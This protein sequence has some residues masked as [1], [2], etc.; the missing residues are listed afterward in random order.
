MV[1]ASPA[2]LFLSCRA[3]QAEAKGHFVLTVGSLSWFL[4]LDIGQQRARS[5]Q[6][7]WQKPP[8]FILQRHYQ[9]GQMLHS[10]T[11]GLPAVG[12]GEG[13]GLITSVVCCGEM[14]CDVELSLVQWCPVLVC[15]RQG[16]WWRSDHCELQV[17]GGGWDDSGLWSSWLQRW[18]DWCVWA[19]VSHILLGPTVTICF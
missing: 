5:S 1:K 14:R 4:D 3:G 2:W 11:P 18:W 13:L 16:D 19:L 12:S 15:G 8:S 10:C 9:G 6:E 17:I 7:Q